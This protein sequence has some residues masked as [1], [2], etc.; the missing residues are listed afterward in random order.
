AARALT[1]ALKQL[2]PSCNVTVADPLITQGPMVVRR[3]ASLYSPVIQR[4]RAAWGAVYHSSNTKPT[5]AAI[6]AVFGPG[7]R[8]VLVELIRK[9]DPDVIL[10]VHPLLNQITHQPIPP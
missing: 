5:F 7:V 4:S 9:H 1:D 2:D 6:R 3:L 8:K 10:S